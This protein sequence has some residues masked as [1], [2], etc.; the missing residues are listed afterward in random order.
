MYHL[1]EDRRTVQRG[2]VLVPEL[3]Y[4]VRGM[5]R[6]LTRYTNYYRQEPRAV[7]SQHFLVRLLQSIHVSLTNDVFFYRQLVSEVSYEVARAVGITTP[8]YRGKIRRGVLF[9][10]INECYMATTAPF[11]INTPWREWEPVQFHRHPFDG[12]M[13]TPLNGGIEGTADDFAV[14]SIN[15]PML[16]A[17]YRQWFFEERQPFNE[18]SPRS[19]MQFVAMYPLT[20][21]VTS[22]MDIAVT[23]RCFKLQMG[24]R[25][26]EIKANIPFMLADYQPVFDRAI[27]KLMDQVESKNYPYTS[28]V[29]Q[30]PTMSGKLPSEVLDLPET[31]MT[32]QNEWI[33]MVARIP[34]VKFLLSVDFVSG[35]RNNRQG[36]NH[37]R[38]VLKQ[39][40][41]D[42]ILQQ[43][44]PR[45][46]SAVIIEDI[47]DNIASY[48]R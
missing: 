42:R 38:R 39:A 30:L 46:L 24:S 4:V 22:Y 36:N 6:N 2:A 17:Q 7:Q 18:E 16:A 26:R 48:L 25:L 41:S 1:L 10:G 3:N 33:F 35:S 44:L 14:L 9:K 12:L 15:I 19:I 8:L 21:A 45:Q 32:R 28:L 29:S 31:T 47:N 37:I 27:E 34:L 40:K 43:S 23:N 13:P 11:D 20:N 5:R